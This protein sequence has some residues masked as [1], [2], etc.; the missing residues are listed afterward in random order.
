MVKTES[1]AE[2]VSGSWLQ[3]GTALE[4]ALDDSELVDYG[5]VTT[6]MNSDFSSKLV[7]S[8]V[9]KSTKELGLSQLRFHK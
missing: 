8:L 9:R 2:T 4:S 3:T 5:E 7:E 1:L 6:G